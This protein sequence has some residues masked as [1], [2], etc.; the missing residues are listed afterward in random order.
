[1][2]W[3]VGWAKVDKADAVALWH[4]RVALQLVGRGFHDPAHLD[5]LPDSTAVKF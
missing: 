3:R 2:T 5:G 1:M 4:Q